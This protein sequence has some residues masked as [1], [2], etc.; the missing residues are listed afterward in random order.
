MTVTDKYLH[1]IYCKN[2]FNHEWIN[3][4]IETEI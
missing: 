1:F 3:F 2:V 4:E